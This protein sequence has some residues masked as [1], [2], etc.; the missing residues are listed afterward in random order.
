MSAD[1][2]DKSA[3]AAERTAAAVEQI[4]HDVRAALQAGAALAEELGPTARRAARQV[5][6]LL[7]R[8]APPPSRK[9]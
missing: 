4:A 5:A 7:A 9:R 1:D 8:Y 2:G 6:D 3:A